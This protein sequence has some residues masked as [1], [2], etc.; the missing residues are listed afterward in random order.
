MMRMKKTMSDDDDD[1]DDDDI[2]DDETPP[3]LFSTPLRCVRRQAN[4][5]TGCTPGC[6]SQRRPEHQCQSLGVAHAN[7]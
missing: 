2:D 4:D 5:D 3:H 6:R 1:D 7:V